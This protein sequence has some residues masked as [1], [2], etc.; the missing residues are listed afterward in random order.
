MKTM[1]KKF[2]FAVMITAII[3]TQLF[4]IEDSLIVK[5][6]NAVDL[7]INDVSSQTTITIKDKSNNVL[8]THSIDKN[9]KFAKSFNLELLKDGDYTFEIDNNSRKKV[10]AITI[11]GDTVKLS[12][13]HSYV[14][15]KPVVNE[16]C[17]LVYV[18]QY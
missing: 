13:S 1:I 11:D 6:K 18:P 17:G 5:D 14:F 7:V 2:A 9:E 3:S 4:A 12:D 15:Y 10:F 16:K 8:Y